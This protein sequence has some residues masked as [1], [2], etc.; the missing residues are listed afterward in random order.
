MG[1]HTP[2]GRHL[3]RSDPEEGAFS[4]SDHNHGQTQTMNSSQTLNTE[5]SAL[6]SRPGGEGG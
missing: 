6:P 5:Q 3:S 4:N 1:L 2:G